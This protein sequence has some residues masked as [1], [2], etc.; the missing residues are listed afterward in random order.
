MSEIAGK[1][2]G[3]THILPVR[4][5]FEDTDAAGVVYH[6]NY[7][8]Y[9]ERGRSDFLRLIGVHHQEMLA[10]EAPLV[11]TLSRI[12]VKYVAPAR[13]DDLLEVHTRF[14][15][16]GG[17][18]LS[19]E[20]AVKKKGMELVTARVEAALVTPSGKPRRVPEE[21]RAQL[22]KYLDA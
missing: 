6:A 14:T 1:F 8:R 9:M 7:L 10:G 21:V 11:W 5:Y 3:K 16:L 15:E 18:R 12:E 13:L 2:S 4:V 19:G 17:A 22:A 20:Q